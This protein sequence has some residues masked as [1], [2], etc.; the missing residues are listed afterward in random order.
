MQ[1][2][3][4]NLEESEMP[5]QLI[6]QNPRA[7]KSNRALENK[8]NP[9]MNLHKHRISAAGVNKHN[10]IHKIIF[11]EFNQEKNLNFHAQY[12]RITKINHK[13]IDVSQVSMNESGTSS[14]FETNKFDWI[15]K[16]S[17]P[18]MSK[19][20]KDQSVVKSELCRQIY[21]P[22]FQVKKKKKCFFNNT[23]KEEDSKRISVAKTPVRRKTMKAYTKKKNDNEDPDLM[24]FKNMMYSHV[25]DF[26]VKTSL[27]KSAN[28]TGQKTKKI[29]TSDQ[30]VGLSDWSTFHG[31]NLRAQNFQYSKV[32]PGSKML[33]VNTTNDIL[34][35]RYSLKLNSLTNYR[36]YQNDQHQ[37]IE[38]FCFNKVSFSRNDAFKVAL[39]HM[40]QDFIRMFDCYSERY[41]QRI[42]LEGAGSLSK[43]TRISL[44]NT[45]YMEV[46]TIN[47][48][49]TKWE[50]FDRKKLGS[51]EYLR[52]RSH[53]Q[54][55][56]Y[57]L[58]MKDNDDFQEVYLENGVP[59]NVNREVS[60]DAG[61]TQ[62][63]EQDGSYLYYLNNMGHFQVNDLREKNCVHHGKLLI[64]DFSE[65][66]SFIFFIF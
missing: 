24:I 51:E 1:N 45:D 12:R 56:Q 48:K 40:N 9:Q 63:M 52:R 17:T 25:I 62:F 13:S 44:E 26:G 15:G 10:F 65:T 30:Y 8:Q 23:T 42:R 29:C 49:V 5:Q 53:N 47:K 60:A 37:Q 11:E 21:L 32:Y 6:N 19:I 58:R 66:G 41:T 3:Q 4:M 36:L 33:M 50:H 34:G 43:N 59:V 39:K 38:D 46:Y 14:V 55:M 64:S 61:I 16:D 18:R 54:N 22:K 31:R 57:E 20:L 28:S 7:S 2:S 27:E 35:M